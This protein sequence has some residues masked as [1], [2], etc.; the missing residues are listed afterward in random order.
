MNRRPPKM[1]EVA[2]DVER[3]LGE[4][5]IAAFRAAFRDALCDAL[6]AAFRAAIIDAFRDAFRLAFSAAFSEPS[7][8][9]SWADGRASS[10]RG[11]WRATCLGPIAIAGLALLASGCGGLPTTRADS[12]GAPDSGATGSL[13]VEV[14]APAAS[15]YLFVQDASLRVAIFA[16]P[17]AWPSGVP[18]D[19]VRAP[20]ADGRGA[21]LFKDLPHGRYAV[22]AF[23]DLDGDGEL[24]RGAFG[25][26]LEPIAYGNDAK[27]RF[28]PPPFEAC[29]VEVAGERLEVV[30]TLVVE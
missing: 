15:G 1:F 25:L 27:P 30:M 21:A 19:R 3:V 8:G 5:S 4:A 9:R 2:V 13:R 14:V 12:V 22:V 23:V 6:R 28:G 26:P 10:R 18:T 24:D 11:R 7:G 17:R 29:A 20:F 16:D